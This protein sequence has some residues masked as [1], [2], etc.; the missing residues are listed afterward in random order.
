MNHPDRMLGLLKEA[1]Q[2]YQ[3]ELEE[4]LRVRLNGRE[5]R[6]LDWLLVQYQNEQKRRWYD[7][8]HILF[9]TIFAL[10]LIEQERL[11]RL[12]VTGIM[13]HDIGYF[14]IDDKTQWD[15]LE[16]RITHMQEGTVLVARVLYEQ[17]FTAVELEKVLGMIAVHDNPYIG[18]EI[19]GKDRLGLRDSD[20]VWVMHPLS[21]YKDLLSKPERYKCPREFLLDRLVQF[22][23]REQPFGSE[24]TI[25]EDRI[26]KNAHRIEIPTYALTREYVTKQFTSRIQEL[27]NSDF[28][29]DVE[30]FKQYLAVQ[31]Q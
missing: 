20:R 17:G 2:T 27:G 31:I 8:C 6:I 23:G 14:A 16:S 30:G 1:A 18:I 29:R 22:Y 7:P 9:S 3:P 12:V 28:M 5:T 24:W 25:T 26:E 21:F 19:K 13:L 10:D 4:K 11:D 15:S